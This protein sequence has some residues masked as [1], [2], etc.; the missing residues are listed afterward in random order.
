MPSDRGGLY[1]F[2]IFHLID[3]GEDTNVE[4]RVND[5][6]LCTARG[7]HY[8]NGAQDPAQATCSVVA[9]LLEGTF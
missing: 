7:D 8:D 5:V 3:L 1:Y 2:S 6:A 4:I 9:D